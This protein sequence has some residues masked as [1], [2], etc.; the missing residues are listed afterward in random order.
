MAQ[1][2]TTE[3]NHSVNDYLQQ[4]SNDKKRTDCAALIQ[5]FKTT[6]GLEPKMWGTSIVGFGSYHYTYESGRQG[7][8][9]LVGLSARANAFSL[10]LSS[11]FEGKF[12]LLQ[13]L[14]KHKLGKGCIYVQKMEDINPHV[15]SKLILH[16]ITYFLQKYPMK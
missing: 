1:N 6:C 7:D 2:K 4:I 13:Q 10:Y 14:G 15:L 12:E 9:P 8:A 16:S 5:L 11:E 3:T